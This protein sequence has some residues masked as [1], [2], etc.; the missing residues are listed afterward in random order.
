MPR[1]VNHEN[2]TLIYDEA[3]A[4][5]EL[6]FTGDLNFQI[7]L[8]ANAALQELDGGRALATARFIVS[9]FTDAALTQFTSADIM[10]KSKVLLSQQMALNPSI[11][12]ILITPNDLEFGLMRMLQGSV[13]SIS[14]W[15]SHVVRTRKEQEDLL[16]RLTGL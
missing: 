13:E 10:Q 15:Q 5:F 8:E 6:R 2:F 12:V 7:W 9:D 14:T 11:T 16:R 3:R 1:Q 4:V